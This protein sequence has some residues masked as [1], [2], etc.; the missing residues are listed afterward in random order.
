MYCRAACSLGDWSVSIFLATKGKDS[1]TMANSG[2]ATRAMPSSTLMAL[3]MS[4]QAADALFKYCNKLLEDVQDVQQHGDRNGEAAHME[5][6]KLLC[7]GKVK[8][9]Q[10][11]GRTQSTGGIRKG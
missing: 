4:L 8:E 3:M 2:L 10:E 11:A 1:S 5:R 9:I 7:P 6:D